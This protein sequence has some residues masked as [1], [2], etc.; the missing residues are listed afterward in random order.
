MTSPASPVAIT[1]LG[2]SSA[3]ALSW[4]RV[5]RMF[6]TVVVKGT[7]ALVPGGP[8]APIEPEPITFE[9]GGGAP[10]DLVPYLGR[11]DVLLVGHVDPAGESRVSPPFT[12]GL[13]VNRGGAW[14]MSKRV[15]MADRRILGLGPS[16]RRAAARFQAHDGI[17]TLP[18]PFDWASLQAAPPDQR[19]DLLEGQEWLALASVYPSHPVLMTHL[20]GARAAAKLFGQA[21]NLRNGRPIPLLADTLLVD[22]DKRRCQIVWRGQF[23]VSGA[24]ALPHLRVVAGIETPGRPIVWIDPLSAPPPPPAPRAAAPPAPWMPITPAHQGASA[25]PPLPSASWSPRPAPPVPDRFSATA[26]PRADAAKPA[27]PFAPP[28]RPE[29][30]EGQEWFHGTAPLTAQQVAELLAKPALPFEA[31]KTIPPAAAS[32]EATSLLDTS[33]LSGLPAIPFG[34]PPPPPPAPAPPPPVMIAPPPIIAPPPAPVA[35]SPPPPLPP[36]APPPEPEPEAPSLGGDFLEA[37]G[38]APKL[39]P[40]ERLAA[41]RRKPKDG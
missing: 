34:A 2:A 13:G 23:P 41:R 26:P 32:H 14:L 28:A 12:V 38:K 19:I 35:D 36:P 7:F 8:V 30:P 6:V 11:A 9:E 31:K 5:D 1:P 4:R 22:A 20:G 37:M 27:T 18:E 10:S 25:P 16:S 39:S 29:E 15:V 40:T 17:L 33:K 3:H 21:Q 24:D